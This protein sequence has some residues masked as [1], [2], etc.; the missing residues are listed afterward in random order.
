MV[1]ESNN[2]SI[3]STIPKMAL[4]PILASRNAPEWRFDS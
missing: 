3:L 4:A 1:F 2:H